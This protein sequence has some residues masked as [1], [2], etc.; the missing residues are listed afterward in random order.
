MMKMVFLVNIFVEN[1]LQDEKKV[2]KVWFIWNRLFNIISVFT[3]TIDQCNTSLLNKYICKIKTFVI[4]NLII[5][6]K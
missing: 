5:E 2:K 1:D 6:L 3:V 4:P